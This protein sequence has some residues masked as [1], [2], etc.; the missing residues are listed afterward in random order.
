MRDSNSR[1]LLQFDSLVNC[2]FKPLSQSSNI[3]ALLKL[4]LYGKI[5]IVSSTLCAEKYETI[6]ISPTQPILHT[7]IR[8]GHYRLEGGIHK[9]I[10]ETRG[11]GH[12]H[13]FLFHFV[14]KKSHS[15][16][17]YRFC[18]GC[19]YFKKIAGNLL[20]NDIKS[21][22]TPLVAVLGLRLRSFAATSVRI[23]SSLATCNK[24]NTYVL[25]LAVAEKRGI[26]LLT[27]AVPVVASLFPYVIN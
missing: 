2:C 23:L 5:G 17:S 4:S 21:F 3:F 10:A 13:G 14:H 26:S 7:Y 24:T 27:G 19:R 9:T 25:V 1:N 12:S 18:S 20:R 22:L 15:L 8:W 16:E 11:F 6:H